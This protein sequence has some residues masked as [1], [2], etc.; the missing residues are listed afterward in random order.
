[1]VYAALEL[2][3]ATVAT[4]DGYPAWEPNVNSEIL[5]VAKEVYKNVLGKEPK[6]EAIHAGLECGLIGEKYPG[7]DMLSCG[8]NL[9]DVHSPDERVS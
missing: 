6:I 3:G 2:G 5:N 9:R 4:G 8:P 1:M 7:I